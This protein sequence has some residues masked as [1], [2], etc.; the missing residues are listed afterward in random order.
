MLKLDSTLFLGLI[1]SSS[2]KEELEGVNLNIKLAFLNPQDMNYLQVTSYKGREYIGKYFFPL[3]EAKNLQSLQIH[4]QSLIKCL[5]PGH[6]CSL[7]DFYLLA[8]PLP[9]I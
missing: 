8:V 1:F 5:L 4:V 2:L 6:L 9:K 7:K 3:I